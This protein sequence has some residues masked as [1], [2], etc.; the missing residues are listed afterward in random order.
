MGTKKNSRLLQIVLAFIA[1]LLLL[2][3]VSVF[4]I[5][6]DPNQ[7]GPNANSWT[8][9]ERAKQWALA[10]AFARCISKSD[11]GG[12]LDKVT[13]SELQ[14]GNWF[15]GFGSNTIYTAPS[16][17]SSGSHNESDYS[18]RGVG[19]PNGV[20]DCNNIAKEVS[21]SFIGDGKFS[22]MEDIFCTIYNEPKRADDS[23]CR[24]SNGGQGD[25]QATSVSANTVLSRISEKVWGTTISLDDAGRYIIYR[26]AFNEFCKPTQTD[27]PAPEYKYVVKEYDTTA[28]KIIDTSYAGSRKNTDFTGTYV[29]ATYAK[30]VG[31]SDPPGAKESCKSMA[32]SLDKYASA[33]GLWAVTHPQEAQ[34]AQSYTDKNNNNTTKSTCAVDGIGWIVCPVMNFVAKANDMAYGFL[35]DNF[36]KIDIEL[37][38]DNDTK[39]AW[40]SFRDIANV[41]FILAFLIIIYSQMTGAGVTNYGIKK[42]LPKLIIAAV[43][44]N[45]SY[46]VCQLAVDISNIVGNSIVKL[47][48][49]VSTAAK[50]ADTGGAGYGL[51]EDAVTLLLAASVSVGLIAAVVVAPSSLLAFAVVLM[52]LLARKALV[53]LLIVISPLAFVAY[54]LPNTEQWF[55]KWWKMFSGMLFVYPMIGV[56]FGAS[57]MAGKIINNAASSQTGDDSW[58]LQLVGLGVTAIPLFVVP[59]LLKSAM[60]AAGAIGAKLSNLSDKTNSFA[61]NRAMKGRLGEA[62]AAFDTR[63]QNRRVKRRAGEGRFG[64]INRAIDS[65]RFG[66]YIGGDKGAAAAASAIAERNEKEISN[67]SGVLT[68]YVSRMDDPTA[69]AHLVSTY[70]KAVESGDTIAARAAARTLVSRGGG[71]VA[72]LREATSKLH[73]DGKLGADSKIDVGDLRH[74]IKKHGDGVKGKDKRLMDWA[75]GKTAD[76]K[77]TKY[78]DTS[79]TIIATQNVDAITA[80]IDSGE[81]SDETAYRLLNSNVSDL[82]KSDAVRA[83]LKAHSATYTPPTP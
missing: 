22:D 13:T 21:S 12:A 2:Q 3:P 7:G 28:N 50:G 34:D 49:S 58:L 74:E 5:P 35:S 4:A 17:L 1:T 71:G 56:I 44:V 81:I 20:M 63:R 82:I 61:K 70:N 8:L 6:Q 11:P 46:I 43:L 27:T 9:A 54:L 80:G 77:T 42:L 67:Q 39:T 53:I 65:S 55:K 64:R 69:T 57:S 23:A 79:D 59:G 40:Q 31:T 10:Q 38:K 19:N 25:Y 47:F 76:V 45:V 72:A 29:Y 48:D 37:L 60:S 52:I 73:D 14:A 32:E 83:A 18:S 26:A 68:D 51:W 15:A 66:K 30:T 16:F 33:Y 24:K 78:T 41:A 75:E 36:L 62:K